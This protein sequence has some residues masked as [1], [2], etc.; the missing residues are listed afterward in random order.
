MGV[1]VG[2]Y[3][4]APT[5]T[6]TFAFRYIARGVVGLIGRI[7]QPSGGYVYSTGEGNDI[8]ADTD[9]P[10]AGATLLV[11]GWLGSW[12]D[13]PCTAPN[14]GDM[15]DPSGSSPC[16]RDWLGDSL[17]TNLDALRFRIVVAGGARFYD[18]IP[19]DPPSHGVFVVRQESGPCA[20]DPPTSSRGCPAWHVLAKLANIGT[21]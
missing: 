7:T 9:W 13:D 19:V 3:M 20:G 2:D 11:Q 12:A 6:G 1:G 5:E 16:L 17:T 10:A 18:S 14:P 15:L 8:S 21:H 4:N